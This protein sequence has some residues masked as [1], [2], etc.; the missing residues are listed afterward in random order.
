M[1]IE[2]PVDWTAPTKD[3]GEENIL[4]LYAQMFA[5]ETIT[6]I[7]AKAKRFDFPITTDIDNILAQEKEVTT[8]LREK[9]LYFYEPD[10]SIFMD[11]KIMRGE[12]YKKIGRELGIE[13]P[14]E[15]KIVG[16][17]K[18]QEQFKSEMSTKEALNT[19]RKIVSTWGWK[20]L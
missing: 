7:C 12:A 13:D 6:M 18:L 19:A 14:E 9:G 8:R 5:N 1:S 4:E 2:K 11:Y 15:A 17:N 3:Y 16:H 10:G 20:S